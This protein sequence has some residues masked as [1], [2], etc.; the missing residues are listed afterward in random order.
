[1][2]NFKDK[3]GNLIL[4]FTEIFPHMKLF[5]VRISSNGPGIPEKLVGQINEVKSKFK[6]KAK[7]MEGIKDGT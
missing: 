4:M 3:Q 6:A 2:K 1:M 7:S 5:N